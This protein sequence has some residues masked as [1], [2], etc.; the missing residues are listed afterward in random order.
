MLSL[1]YDT[2]IFQSNRISRAL[3]GIRTSLFQTVFSDFAPM[4]TAIVLVLSMLMF[5][6]ISFLKYQTPH[7]SF[8][9]HQY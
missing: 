5:S 2:K 8:Y 4:F 9:K 1:E 7:S 3:I 6:D